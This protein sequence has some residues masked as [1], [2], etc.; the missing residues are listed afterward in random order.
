MRTDAMLDAGT[1]EKRFMD[2]EWAVDNGLTLHSLKAP[3]QLE[4]FDIQEG[5][6]RAHNPLC[7]NP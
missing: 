5:R 4:I 3:I 2:K 1:E 7:A 6:G